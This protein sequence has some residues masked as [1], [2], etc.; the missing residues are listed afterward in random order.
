MADLIHGQQSVLHFLTDN[1]HPENHLLSRSIVRKDKQY[2]VSVTMQP[3]PGYEKKASAQ[4]NDFLKEWEFEPEV[5][6]LDSTSDESMNEELASLANALFTAVFLIF[7]AMAIQF[8]S[9]KYS[10]M[11]MITIPFSLIGAF[12]LLFWA[13]SPISMTSMLGFLMMVGNVVNS[14]ILYVETVNQLKDEMS[15]DEA[16][17]ES[18]AIDREFWCRLLYAI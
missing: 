1:N 7:I 10:L 2:Q 9:P 16:L 15:L 6:R 13:D 17:V 14:G 5:K 4:I 18:G 11:V 12:G 8:E 3:G